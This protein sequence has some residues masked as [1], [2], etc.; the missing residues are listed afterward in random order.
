[1]PQCQQKAEAVTQ[2]WVSVMQASF[3]PGTD[4]IREPCWI[5]PTMLHH[6]NNRKQKGP[7]FQTPSGN[8]APSKLA[9]KPAYLCW[10]HHLQLFQ[11]VVHR[12]RFAKIWK[13]A[14]WILKFLRSSVST[15]VL[16]TATAEHNIVPSTL[17]SL[18][19]LTVAQGMRRYTVLNKCREAKCY[20]LPG[21]IKT[22]PV[23]FLLVTYCQALSTRLF[24]ETKQSARRHFFGTKSALGITTIVNF[25]PC[26][27][28]PTTRNETNHWQQYS[29]V[30]CCSSC[31][32]NSSEMKMLS[33][34][35]FVGRTVLLFLFWKSFWSSS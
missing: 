9:S 28:H 32:R 22:I 35:Y 29:C 5:S 26:H 11:T 1:M 3:H 14:M 13:R 34:S 25:N 31:P 18:R 10:L 21:Y 4:K 7:S 30:F 23:S 19:A 6:L 27:K 16:C 33:S 2:P 15:C 17:V 12:L 8:S 24:V 20:V